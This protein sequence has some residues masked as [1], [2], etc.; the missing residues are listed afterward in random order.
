MSIKVNLGKKEKPKNNKLDESSIKKEISSEENKNTAD[1]SKTNNNGS[2]QRNDPQPIDMDKLKEELLIV[3]QEQEE[4][5]RKEREREI[6]KR[7]EELKRVEEELKEE[8]ENISNNKKYGRKSK[9]LIKNSPD[10]N[11]DYYNNYKIRVRNQKMKSIAF[12]ATFYIFISIILLCNGYF[13]F[14]KQETPINTIEQ[15]V[16]KN[17][18]IYMFPTD[19]VQEYL[20]KNL[21]TLMADNISVTGG[22]GAS[23]WNIQQ[24]R[25]RKFNLFSD[26]YANVYFS[27]DISTATG[28]A[29]HNFI[30]TLK[31]DYTNKTYAPASPVITRTTSFVDSTQMV[32]EDNLVWGFGENKSKEVKNLQVFL[33][34]YYTLLYNNKTYP[35]ASL[36][37]NSTVTFDNEEFSFNFIEK[38]EWYDVV[39][40]MGANC[41]VTYSVKSSEG[42]TY[43][44]TNYLAVYEDGYGSYKITNVY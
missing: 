24:I 32:E 17:L 22:S 39:N 27:A 42:L 25:I 23:N 28:T 20:E 15:T 16:K 37:L 21:S 13:I 12:T 36:K 2:Y 43:L 7:E 35:A 26:Q 5:K 6:K 18:Y 44:V 29:E 33:E 30:L 40:Y 38:V 4:K 3:L 19:G 9:M 8:K 10:S 11:E 41:K 1:N 31:Y 14:I 34:Q